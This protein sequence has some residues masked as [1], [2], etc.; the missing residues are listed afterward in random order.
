MTKRKPDPFHLRKKLELAFN[1][2]FH[3]G[4][5]D[6]CDIWEKVCEITPGVG[7]VL[8]KRMMDTVKAMATERA[9]L[10]IR[11]EQ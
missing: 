11:K 4:Y 1:Q 8:Q 10:K 2:G 3:D 9:L 5:M 6:A 7:P